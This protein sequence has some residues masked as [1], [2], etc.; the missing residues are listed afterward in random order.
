M[1]FSVS[2]LPLKNQLR[3]L[4]ARIVTIWFDLT[5]GKKVYLKNTNH[6]NIDSQIFTIG[7]R[8]SPAP[9]DQIQNNQQPG[10]VMDSGFFVLR[11]FKSRPKK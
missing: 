4:V 8:F 11:R 5:G 2:K 10:S 6:Q 3:T 9:L 7:V 1:N